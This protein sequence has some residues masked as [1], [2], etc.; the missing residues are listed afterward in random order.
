MKNIGNDPCSLFNG[1]HFSSNKPI[2]ALEFNSQNTNA[3]MGIRNRRTYN[4]I[5]RVTINMTK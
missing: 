4:I 3:R 5:S 2:L 1:N